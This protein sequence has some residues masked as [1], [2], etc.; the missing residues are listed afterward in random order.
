MSQFTPQQ[1]RSP[2]RHGTVRVSL[3]AGL[4]AAAGTRQLEIPW[5]G[6]TAADLR[7]AVAAAV[8]AAA[9]LVVK[10]AVAIGNDYV[11]DASGVAAGAEIA[12]IPPVSGG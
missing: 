5:Q 6:G 3:F 12:I 8:P 1:S 11:A 7:A 2:S 4:A 10:S 9:A